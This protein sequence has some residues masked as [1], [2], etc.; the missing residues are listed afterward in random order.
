MKLTEKV[1]IAYLI[2]KKY[3]LS[4]FYTDFITHCLGCL[5]TVNSFTIISIK[6]Y[7]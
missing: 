5:T 3:V 6:F 1:L 4:E 2:D 7:C